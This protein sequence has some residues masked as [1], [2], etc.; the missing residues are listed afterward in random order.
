MRPLDQYN[1]F[2]DCCSLICHNIHQTDLVC[3]K[4][5]DTMRMMPH[6]KITKHAPR[7]NQ[8]H[9]GLI[10]Q[11]GGHGRI[12]KTK[13]APFFIINWAQGKNGLLTEDDLFSQTIPWHNG[14]ID[15]HKMGGQS[16]KWNLACKRVILFIVEQKANDLCREQRGNAIYKT[17]KDLLNVLHGAKR[18][19]QVGKPNKLGNAFL[20]IF[21]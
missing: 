6:L 4:S 13:C 15:L 11:A 19:I 21:I 14:S 16:S 10:T 8:R 20:F 12:R 2:D 5:R 1:I 3:A 17:S 9:K 18:L 7:G